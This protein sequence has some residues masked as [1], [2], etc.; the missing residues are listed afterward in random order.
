MV[1]CIYPGT[2]FRYSTMHNEIFDNLRYL[3]AGTIR[4]QRAYHLLEKYGLMETLRAFDP[5]LAGTIPINIDVENSDLD[6]ICC[7]TDKDVF[8]TITSKTFSVFKGFTLADTIINDQETIVVNFNVEGWPVEV[9]G[10]YI[11]TR[12][13]NAYQHMIAEHQLLQYFGEAF[14][15]QIIALKNEEYKTEPAFA[16][17]LGLT[18]DPYLALL[19]PELIN[20]LKN[21]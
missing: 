20:R 21:K 5:I 8:K 17:A 4:Q 16:K 6:I 3:R 10:Q 14:R 11:P 1:F 19:D 12:E 13:Q 7:F 15:Q 2:P 9:F 18:G